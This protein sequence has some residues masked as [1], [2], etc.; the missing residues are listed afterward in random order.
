PVY[1][2]GL[3]QRLWLE[4]YPTL[5]ATVEINNAF[6]RLPERAT[7]EQWRRRTPAGFVFAVK[8]S[9]YLTHIRR[10]RD[11]AQPVS[12][13]PHR[14]AGL[15][16][17]FGPVLLPLP[18]PMTAAPRLL[19]ETLARFPAHVR[20]VVELRHYSWFTAEVRDVLTARNAA[21]CWAD[22]LARPTA[23]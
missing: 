16:E 12:R 23:P 14:V 10:L 21:L 4:H 9:R 19:D 18:P 20:V 11:P 13:L 17:Q 7:F 15:E 8:I 5:F 1:P 6:Y 2:A 22:R 3:P